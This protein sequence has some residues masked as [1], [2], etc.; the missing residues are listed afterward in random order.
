MKNK[1][2]KLFQQKNILNH[3]HVKPHCNKYCRSLH[4][5]LGYNYYILDFD[6]C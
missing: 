6:M 1:I 5:V 4:V 2:Q 3:I